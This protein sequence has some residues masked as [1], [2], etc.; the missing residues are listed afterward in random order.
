MA[1]RGRTGRLST[2]NSPGPTQAD[3]A[4]STIK[5]DL[6]DA[7]DE[8]VGQT[9]G[10]YKLWERV[11]E[12]GCGVVHV[13]EQTEPVQ[14]R[15]AL[16]VIKL[17]LSPQQAEISGLDLDTRSASPAWECCSTNRWPGARRSMQRRGWP[18]ASTR[19]ARRF[20]KKSRGAPAKAFETSHIP[21]GPPLRM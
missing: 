2:P 5:P 6:A 7:P 12:G 10:R 3:A 8:V 17:G 15:V 14:R 18:P 13:A 19:C 21:S 4:R 11:G 1:Q 20:G 9:L 16:K